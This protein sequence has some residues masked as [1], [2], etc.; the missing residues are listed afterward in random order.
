MKNP[1]ATELYLQESQSKANSAFHYLMVLAFIFT[2][3][4]IAAFFMNRK[5]MKEVYESE[6]E[7]L[8]D[9]LLLRA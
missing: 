9:Y 4:V 1:A 5:N 7:H 6:N 8:Y 3:L 2:L